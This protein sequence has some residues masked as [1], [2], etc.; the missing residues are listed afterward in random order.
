MDNYFINSG[1]ISIIFVL[2]KFA[3][4]KIILKEDKPLKVILRDGIFVYLSSVLGMFLI[5]QLDNTTSSLSSAKPTNAF[6]GNPEF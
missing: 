2:L 6:I 5:N 1:I 3:E 4:M